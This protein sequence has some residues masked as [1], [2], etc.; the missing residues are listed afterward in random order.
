MSRIRDKFGTLIRKQIEWLGEDWDIAII[1]TSKTSKIRKKLGHFYLRNNEKILMGTK[2]GHFH[3]KNHKNRKNQDIFYFALIKF[4]KLC[5]NHRLWQIKDKFENP[6]I[7]E[8][9][10][11]FGTIKN[12]DVEGMKCCYNESGQKAIFQWIFHHFG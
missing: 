10:S 8:E 2:L 1:I 4:I 12:P 3:L 11:K 9:I 6:Q 5:K 7:S